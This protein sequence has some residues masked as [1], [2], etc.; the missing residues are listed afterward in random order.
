[1]ETFISLWHS[2]GIRLKRSNRC[3]DAL[4]RCKAGAH[5]VRGTLCPYHSWSSLCQKT[6]RAKSTVLKPDCLSYFFIELLKK[7]HTLGSSFS[8]QI[9]KGICNFFFKGKTLYRWFSSVTLT[10]RTLNSWN[11]SGESKFLIWLCFWSRRILYLIVNET[12]NVR[13]TRY[14]LPS[15][16]IKVWI[17]L[18][19]STISWLTFGLWSS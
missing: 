14:I 5:M 10:T 3:D 11:W 15:S 9:Q 18:F 19:Y 16:N 1:M 2:I 6:E 17:I 13:N 8:F 4:C 12:N 7:M